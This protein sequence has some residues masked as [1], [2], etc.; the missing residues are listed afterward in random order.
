MYMLNP[1][2]V[3]VQVPTI[4]FVVEQTLYRSMNVMSMDVGGRCP[5]RPLF[6]H[7]YKDTSGLIY[8]LDINEKDNWYVGRQKDELERLLAEPD[9][10]GLPLLI[11][12]NKADLPAAMSQ[13]EL[14][15]YVDMRAIQKTRPVSVRRVSIMSYKTDP[16]PINSSF[17]WLRNQFS[18]ESKKPLSTPAV[19]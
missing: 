7:Y 10:I 6:R 9:L 19:A 13:E 8:V 14:E 11:L 5:M 2:E 12:G 1:G 18:T 3:S 17:K 4:G 15:N 16:E